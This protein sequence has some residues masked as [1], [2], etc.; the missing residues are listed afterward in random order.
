MKIVES[1]TFEV[2][3]RA[4]AWPWIA[5]DPSHR[6]F[7]FVT[8]EGAIASRALEGEALAVGSSFPLPRDLALPGRRGADDDHRGAPDGLHAFAIRQDG[9]RVATTARVGDTSIVAV[10]G[11]EGELRR[12]SLAGLGRPDL[13]AH[14]ITFDRTGERLWVSAESGTVTA[15][16]CLDATSL[17]LHGVVESAPFPPAASHEL[18]VHP[19]DDAVILLAACGQ[20]G[21]FARVA[22]FSDGPP[23]AVETAL[24]GGAVP[25]GFVGISRDGARVYLVDDAELRTHAWPT[26]H[27]LAEAELADD[28]ATSY[29]GA[30]LGDRILLDGHDDE[31]GDFDLVIVFD[32]SGLRGGLARPPVPE[33]MW[34]GRLGDDVLVTVEAKG[35]P[36]R[37][38][39][40]RL[41]APL[42]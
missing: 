32:R 35:E 30:V 20:E 9:E 15:I 27:P 40:Y 23:V 6:R 29:S 2:A 1:G 12:V 18:H 39:V 28:F 14:A 38:R 19:I 33:G 3:H 24:D 16:V 36:A 17:A 41:P 26:L 13:V 37:G 21:T 34:A 22:G 42:G 10:A 8:A 31:T 4:L 25:S 11:T 7:A 5:F